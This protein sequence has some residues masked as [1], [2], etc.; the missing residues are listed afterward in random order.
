MSL[1]E[2][3][4]RFAGQFPEGRTEMSGIVETDIQGDIRHQVAGIQQKLFRVSDAYGIEVIGK[5]DPVL[6]VKDFGQMLGS[7][8]QF[9][10]E[11]SQR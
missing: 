6:F 7:K 9:F 4:R 1:P 5:T 3:V 2:G 8:T 11:I 10:R